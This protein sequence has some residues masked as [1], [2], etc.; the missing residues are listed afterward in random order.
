VLTSEYL[1]KTCDDLRMGRS[2]LYLPKLESSPPTILDHLIAYFPN[3]TAKVWRERVQGGRVTL[4]DGTP[5]PQDHAYQHGITIYY[6]RE[7]ADEPSSPESETILLQD[8]EI[9]VADKPHGMPV[10]PGG[11]YVERSLL[12]RL[13]KSTGLTD[14]SP[15]HRL[16]RE[17]AGLVLF[18]VKAETRGRYQQL[19]EKKAIEREYFAIAHV[20]STLAQKHWLVENRIEA[21]TPWFTQRIVEGLPNAKTVIGLVEVHGDTG[22]FRLTPKTGKKHQL[23]VHMAS[24]GAPI[25]GDPFY[26]Q[27]REKEESEPPLQLLAHRLAFTD[28]LNSMPRSFTSTRQLG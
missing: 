17:T 15:I 8:D 21:G 4:D 6:E 25:V 7:A 5:L 18:S 28:P 20:A 19:F 27:V 10:T 12:F 14:L 9:L 26:P 1:I 3:V 16:D 23:R 2:R 22:L 24:I 13:Q 11:D